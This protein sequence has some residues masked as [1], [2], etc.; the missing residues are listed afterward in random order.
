MEK[1]PKTNRVENQK[2]TAERVNG[3]AAMMGFWA[4]VGAYLTTGQIIPGVV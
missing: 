3:M 2:L 1:T 4:A